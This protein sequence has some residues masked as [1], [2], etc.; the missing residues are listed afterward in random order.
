MA[1]QPP[2]HASKSPDTSAGNT[3][4]LG[5]A[6][7]RRIAQRH[8]DNCWIHLM[9][10]SRPR[11]LYV[12][13]APSSCRQNPVTPLPWERVARDCLDLEILGAHVVAHSRTLPDILYRRTARHIAVGALRLT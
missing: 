8:L 11:F 7:C 3:G 2:L 9:R 10:A 6:P 4:L 13:C 5:F 12:C 1:R